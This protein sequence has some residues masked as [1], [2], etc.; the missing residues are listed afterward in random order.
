ME[1]VR[2][3]VE[4]MWVTVVAMRVTVKAVRVARGACGRL[5]G[6]RAEGRFGGP[7]R[8]FVLDAECPHSPP[9]GPM[10]RTSQGHRT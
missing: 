10:P 6:A 5:A 1:A 8:D 7:A 2:V 3:T 4:A 9:M